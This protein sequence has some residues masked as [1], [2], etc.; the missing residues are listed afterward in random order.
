MF[1]SVLAKR[2]NAPVVD[3]VAAKGRQAG[4]KVA[5]KG[6]EVKRAVKQRL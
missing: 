2:A 6:R 1:L 3:E 5:D 4:R